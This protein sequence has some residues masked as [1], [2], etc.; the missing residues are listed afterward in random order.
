[1]LIVVIV[2]FNV[3]VHLHRI[4]SYNAKFNESHRP[5]YLY[6]GMVCELNVTITQYNRHEFLR[7]HV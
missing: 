6:K 4:Q 5:N 2:N 3:R 1:M 7:F